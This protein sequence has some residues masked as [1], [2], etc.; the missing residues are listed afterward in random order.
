MDETASVRELP[1]QENMDDDDLDRDIIDDIDEID[2][3]SPSTVKRK[4]KKIK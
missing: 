4:I 3:E 1:K 2:E